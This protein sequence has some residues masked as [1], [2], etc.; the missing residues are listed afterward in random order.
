MTDKTITLPESVV[1]RMMYRIK[2]GALFDPADLDA[3][4]ASLAEPVPP[5]GGE[6]IKRYGTVV[7]HGGSYEHVVL[8]EFKNGYVVKYVDHDAIVTRL[9]AEVDKLSLQVSEY[10]YTCDAVYRE[11]DALQSELA[12]ARELLEHMLKDDD[13]PVHWFAQRIDNYLSNQS[14]PAD[15]GSEP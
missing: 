10:D 9:Q 5:A 12:T 11:R 2:E 3:V 15:K 1:R 7:S 14:A 8:E 6:P 4:L 13:M